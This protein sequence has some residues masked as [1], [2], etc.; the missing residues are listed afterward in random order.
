MNT[1]EKQS[2]NA[3]I[4][5]YDRLTDIY[6]IEFGFWIPQY[7]SICYNLDVRNQYMTKLREM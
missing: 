6:K 7:K 2:I 1:Q 5:S 3:N 4:R